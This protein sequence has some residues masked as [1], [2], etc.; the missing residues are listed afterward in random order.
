MARMK[1][2]VAYDGT[3]FAGYQI[4]PVGRTVQGSIQ[5]VLQKVHKGEFVPT[6]AS[7]RTDAGVHAFG[8]VVHFDTNMD[9]PESGWVRGL[10]AML[11]KDIQ[12]R[13]VEKMDE[14]FHARFS[15]TSKEYHYK[16][17]T[18]QQ[19]DIFRR[20]QTFHYPYPLN[21]SEMKKAC[22]Y[23]LGTHD[24]TSFSS[25][26]T[27]VTDKV[28][29]IYRLEMVED[30]EELTFKIKG[31]GFLYN[32]VRII[33]GTLLDVGRGKKRPEEIK[34]ILERKDRSFASKTAPAHGL[35]LIQVSYDEETE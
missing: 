9:I 20:N 24:F 18:G 11:P 2:T 30:G 6:S 7:G 35:Y 28:R 29:T 33:V 26:K 5:K 27:H 16:L 10:N 14:S 32:M 3:D 31:T 13:N 12:V 4:Q 21:R 34:T 8:Q 1:V 17:L 15:S 19:P 25:V 22:E 23:F